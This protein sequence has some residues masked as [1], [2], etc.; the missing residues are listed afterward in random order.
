VV[1]FK[2]GARKDGTLAAIEARLV[3]DT[4]AFA[5]DG[6]MVASVGTFYASQPYRIPH[7]KI[8]GYAVY[9]NHALCGAFRGFGN[10][11]QA[12]A[13][14]SMMDMIAEKLG[15]D[16]L[17]LRLKN[18][19]EGGD[20]IVIG[21][22]VD[23]VGLKE[24]LSK[25]ARGIGWKSDKPRENRGQGLASL[26]HTSANLFTQAVVKMQQDG[27]LVLSTGASDI[28]QGSDTVLCQIV[29]ETMGLP[30]ED[31]AVSTPDT[32]TSPY[33]WATVAS[34][35]TYVVGNAARLAAIDVKAKIFELAAEELDAAPHL[36]EIADR[37]VIVPGPSGRRIS[38]QEIATKA[39]WRKG[40]P[41]MG[42]AS[43][44]MEGPG[45]DPEVCKLTGA[46]L[47]RRGGFVF[48]SHAVEVEVDPAT[49]QVTVLKIAAAHDVGRAVNPMGVEGQ[50]QGGFAMG[51]GYALYEEIRYQD[52]RV[53][54]PSF[55]DYRIPTMLD[56][57]DIEAIIVEEADEGGPFGA[58]GVGEPGL[59][60]VAP[61]VAN[62]IYNAVGVRIREL[63]IT[64]EKLYWALKEK[65]GK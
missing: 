39:H 27:T 59:V 37:H 60:G 25:S 23:S 2:V 30:L 42:V 13:F 41:I 17:E 36:L 47:R 3:Y 65:R 53:L 6:P 63:P 55:L 10:P 11:Q 33:N 54:N 7:V 4:G 38:L 9:T 32:D 14:E 57:P 20:S 21:Q 50:I 22:T 64:A 34:R 48:G 29:A 52:G 45:F 40:G 12:Y 26:W 18:A 58:K 43:F 5:D 28:G 46:V 61:A 16:P 35:T 8:D 19:L 24:C 62:A 1:D 49:G 51:L 44:G 56:V 15:I 31:V